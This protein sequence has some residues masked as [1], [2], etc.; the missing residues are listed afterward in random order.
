MDANRS[1]ARRLRFSM[2][3]MRPV[4]LLPA[5]VTTT[6]LA[7]CGGSGDGGTPPP[8]P[9]GT[10][11]APQ[12][13]SP[14]AASVVENMLSAYQASASDPDGNALT[15]TISGGSDAARFTI[16]AA[17]ALAFAAA[18]DFDLPG[19]TD[20]NNVYD[21]QLTVSDGSASATQA[22]S[23]TVTNSREGI[24]VRRIATGFVQPLYVAPIPGSGDVWVLEKAGRIWRV[25]PATGN[26]SLAATV[27]DISTDGERGL[28]AI[29]ASDDFTETGGSVLIL[30]TAANGNVEVRNIFI[31]VAPPSPSPAS[32]ILSIPHPNF[33]NHNG[34]WLGFGPDGL[35]YVT[36]GD[37]GGAGDP[38]NNAQNPASQL[39]KVLRLQRN[40]NPLGGGPFQ[41][42]IPAPGNPFIGGGG[43]PFVYALGLRNPF[44]ASFSGNRLIIGD[45]GQDAIEEISM[46]T[47][48][49]PGINFGWRFREGTRTFSGNPP[50]GLTPPVAEYSHG[51]GPRQG[52]S[53]TGGY[54]YRGPVASLS[55]NYV[56]GDFISG[57]LWTLPLS[58]LVAGQTQSSSRFR[59]RNLDFAP[60]A[61]TIGAPVSFG[62]DSSGNLY[63]VD[64]DGELFV[65]E[66]G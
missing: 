11:R 53:V 4:I 55:G 56:F 59:Q 39:G 58:E 50:A 26:R 46:L 3:A 45:V 12:F 6:L 20:G 47:T 32:V 17:G 51:P 34:G 37:G 25:N 29:T 65:V 31:G 66:P 18:P 49:Q 42:F 35:L 1:T 2:K 52:E 41:P 23:I 48:T 15:F 5:A 14:A 28:L 64:F 9:Q 60:D 54:V 8:P 10:N 63:I 24:A 27:T 13:T 57:N 40:P 21:V 33:N 44:R 16:T 22:V 62:E 36:T 61:G 43:D 7:A 19:D 38:G 30:V